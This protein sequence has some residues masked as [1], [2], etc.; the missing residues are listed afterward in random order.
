M[1]SKFR[2]IDRSK[3]IQIDCEFKTVLEEDSLAR[4]VVDIVDAL[5]TSEMEAKYS[6][7]GNKGYPPKMMLSLIFYCYINGTFSSRKI[8][9]SV[10]ELI[11]VMYITH[12]E[13]PGHS[14][15]SRFRKA[16]GHQMKSFFI[17]ILEIAADMGVLTL[18]NVALDGTKI[19]ANASRHKA[20][21]YEYAIKLSKQIESEIELLF[22]KAEEAEG[23]DFDGLNIP[24]EIKRRKDRLAVI[25]AAKAEIE[26]RAKARYEDEKR[27]YDEK[28][29]EREAKEKERGGKL[30]GKKPVEPTPEP[31]PSDQV[32]LT[33]KES[34]IMP[35]SNKGFKQAYNAQASVDMD[36]RLIVQKHVTQN[37]NDK[38]ELSPALE[39][40]KQLPEGLGRV[41]NLAADS[42]YD[43]HE[44]RRK[45][46]DKGIDLHLPKGRE[47]HNNFLKKLIENKDSS[48]S[49]KARRELYNRRKSTIEPVFGVIK[50]VI[51]FTKFSLRGL[52]NVS[53]EWDLVCIAY[54]L[55]R[56]CVIKAKTA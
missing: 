5:D 2:E 28:V 17:Q 9:K 21:S 15:I 40:I 16:F 54:N 7:Y 49:D 34:R 35:D 37:T 44:N 48:V 24:E 8:E 46:D 36:S 6:I 10:N 42:G 14:V 25:K 50:A 53:N 19:G 39:D 38:R 1:V 31:K 27:L 51:G 23:N 43:S 30:G 41:K 56:L 45:A 4:F 18:G 20:L 11:P 3:S 22:K 32:N 55:K 12:G 33:D 26:A 29:A 47:K 13:K 52:K